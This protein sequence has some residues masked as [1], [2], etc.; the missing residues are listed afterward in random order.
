MGI[1]V[2]TKM[3]TYTVTLR[4]YFNKDDDLVSPQTDEFFRKTPIADYV[5]NTFYA[6]EFLEDIVDEHEIKMIEGSQ[7]WNNDFSVSFKVNTNFTKDE[8]Y[9]YLV[10][11]NLEDSQYEVCDENGWVILTKDDKPDREYGLID[12]RKYYCIVIE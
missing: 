10:D 12:Y 3:N 9:N 2:T 6:E 7:K 1:I 5:I 4:L 11:Q 8:V